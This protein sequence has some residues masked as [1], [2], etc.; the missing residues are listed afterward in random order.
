MKFLVVDDDLINR[1]LLGAL[2]SKYGESD[3]AVNGE[4]AT[5]FYQRN[6]ESKQYY[7]VVFLDIMMPEM[8][9]HEALKRMREI[10]NEFGVHLGHGAEVV[11]V[12][13]LGDRRN[14]LSAFSE[15]CEYYLVKPIDQAKLDEMLLQIKEER[16]L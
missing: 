15:G 7:D 3:F 16:G 13:A 6:L 14:V 12:S 11:M 1:R 4:E 2:L 8:N 10:E 9:G 5:R